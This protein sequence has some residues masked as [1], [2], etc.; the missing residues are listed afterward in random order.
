MSFSKKIDLFYNLFS[1]GNMESPKIIYTHYI[2]DAEKLF[3]WGTMDLK[4]TEFVWIDSFKIKY[5]VSCSWSN[6]EGLHNIKITE[7]KHGVLKPDMLLA[8]AKLPQNP[9]LEALQVELRQIEV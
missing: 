8:L 6:A 2:T 5:D 7:I 4:S 1:V 9:I 3:W